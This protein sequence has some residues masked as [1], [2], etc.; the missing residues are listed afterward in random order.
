MTTRF[1]SHRIQKGKLWDSH[2]QRRLHGY[3]VAAS[4]SAW[5]RDVPFPRARSHFSKLFVG[6][7]TPL[8]LHATSACLLVTILRRVAIPR[9]WLA[10]F[11][12]ALS[13]VQRTLLAGRIV[14]FYLGKLLC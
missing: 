13:G 4:A 8:M 7:N 10:G 3:F 6:H 9:A 12:F 1:L 11:L 2:Y 14:W 5:K